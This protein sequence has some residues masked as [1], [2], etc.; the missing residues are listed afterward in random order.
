MSSVLSAVVRM[1]TDKPDCIPRGGAVE[2]LE[3]I[4]K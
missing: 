1:A 4:S 3:V 2:D